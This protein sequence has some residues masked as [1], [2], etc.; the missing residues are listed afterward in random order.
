MRLFEA[1]QQEGYDSIRRFVKRWRKAQRPSVTHAFVPLVFAPGAKY[2]FDWS[3]E[4][5]ELG[6]VIQT[7]KVAHFRLCY[8][9]R[10]SVVAYPRETQEMVFDAHNRALAAWGGVPLAGI[11]VPHAR[12]DEPRSG[13]NEM[14]QE[15]RSRY[16]RPEISRF[17]RSGTHIPEGGLAALSVTFSKTRGAQQKRPPG[18]PSGLFRSSLSTSLCGA[19]SLVH[20]W[21]LPSVGAAC[22]FL[23]RSLAAWLHVLCSSVGLSLVRVR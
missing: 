10:P 16:S 15:D 5:V 12:G 23:A 18:C 9:R 2:P 8:S 4:V 21:R 19:G 3:H 1:L 11:Y 14:T 13:V 20:P 17:Q 7:I 22:A 6:G